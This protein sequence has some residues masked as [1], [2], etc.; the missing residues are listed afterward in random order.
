MNNLPPNFPKTTFSGQAGYP[1]G[2]FAGAFDPAMGR[3]Y[4]AGNAVVIPAGTSQAVVNHGIVN[5]FFRW[6]VSLHVEPG[7]EVVIPALTAFFLRVTVTGKNENDIIEREVEVPLIGGGQVV[8]VPGRSLIVM[9]ENPTDVDLTLHYSL[10]EATPGLSA[11]ETSELFS[12]TAGVETALAIPNFANSIQILSLSGGA[13][14]ILR[15]YDMNGV[16]TYRETLAPPRSADV[17]LA[18]NLVYTLEPTVGA[19]VPCNVLYQ[20]AG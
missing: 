17:S 5:Q 8:Y 18:P 11:W 9:V 15:G 1:A 19:G 12:L 16:L 3:G 7:P 6:K 2:R 10:D 20:C 13:S 4:R 14:W